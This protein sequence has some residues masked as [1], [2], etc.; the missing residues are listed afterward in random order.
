MARHTTARIAQSN[1]L[2]FDMDNPMELRPA[3]ASEA[4]QTVGADAPRSINVFWA[5]FQRILQEYVNAMINLWIHPCTC[6]L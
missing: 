4:Q 2:E 1:W 3:D 6:F 5:I